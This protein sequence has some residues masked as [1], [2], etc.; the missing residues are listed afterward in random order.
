M[1]GNVPSLMKDAPD[2]DVVSVFEV[3]DTVREAVEGPGA[4]TREAEFMPMPR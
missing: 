4:Q 2:L 1:A 3:E